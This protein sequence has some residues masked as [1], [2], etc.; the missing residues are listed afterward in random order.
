[1]TFMSHQPEIRPIQELETTPTHKSKT[2]RTL[3]STEMLL[4]SS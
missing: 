1:M 4:P 2:Q 3:L